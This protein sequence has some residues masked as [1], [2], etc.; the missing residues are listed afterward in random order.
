ME[1]SRYDLTLQDERRRGEL[2]AEDE[3]R[4]RE[5]ERQRRER[6]KA[7]STMSSGVKTRTADGP[8]ALPN[9]L[10]RLSV[11]FSRQQFADAERLA[12][13]ILR[14]DA[15]QPLPYAVLGDI[16]RA[17]GNLED[18]AK[19]YSYALQMAPTNELFL[20]RYE[21]IL[22]RA[23][24]TGGIGKRARLEPQEQRTYAILF[25]ILIGLL[26]G[27]YVM[28]ASDKPALST[29]GPVSTWTLSLIVMLF[30]S[31]A[32][33]G[34]ALSVF[35]LVDRLDSTSTGKVSPAVLM[36]LISIVS[37]P[38]ACVLYLAVG[39]SQRAFN[40]TTTRMVCAVA[41]MTLWLAIASI[42]T[43]TINFGQVVIW[44]GNLTYLGALG[45]WMVADSLRK[46]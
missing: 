46:T 15:H 32:A 29:L 11:M 25:M 31:G 12:R 16:C 41:G 42:P 13:E 30:V 8:V 35:N 2:K 21:E 39:F 38:A 40:I 36:G 33:S 4:R 19:M 7:A 34:A 43:Q 5:Q 24:L 17:R 20:K 23:Q 37:F 27:I 22:D 44:G 9:M 28:V 1:R 18:A 10:T 26:A 14:I 3:R 6:E 45:G